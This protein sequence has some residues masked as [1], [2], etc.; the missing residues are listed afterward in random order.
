MQRATATLIQGVAEC[1]QLL[2][3]KATLGTAT[4]AGHKIK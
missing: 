1:D 2:R 4:W 3:D